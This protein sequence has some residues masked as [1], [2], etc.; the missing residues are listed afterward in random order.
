M[1]MKTLLLFPRLSLAFAALGLVGFAQASFVIDDF[2][3]ANQ[4]VFA[5]GSGNGFFRRA[6]GTM[7]GGSR[8]VGVTHDPNIAYNGYST[9]NV[10]GGAF[11]AGSDFGIKGNF[12]LDYGTTGVTSDNVNVF[13]SSGTD[14]NFTGNDSFRVN[15]LGNEKRLDLQVL[16]ISAEYDGTAFR[17]YPRF[18]GVSVEANGGPFS[19]TLSTANITS[20]H[21]SFDISKVDFVRFGFRNQFGGDFGIDSVE[22]VPEPASLV[23]LGTGAVALLRRRRSR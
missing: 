10:S 5:L 14:F 8:V 20:S 15:F 22:A 9:G 7:F 4:N 23:A 13:I 2:S 18:Y 11:T 3:S 16:L 1:T 21:A 6:T 19:V 17:Q 12:N